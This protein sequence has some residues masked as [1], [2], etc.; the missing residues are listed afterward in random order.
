MRDHSSS[1]DQTS[2]DDLFRG[3]DATAEIHRATDWSATSLGP[4]ATW[5][6]DLRAAVR[7]VLASRIPMLLWWGPDLVQ[8]YN[9]AYSALIGEKHPAAVGQP[10]AACWAEIWADIGPLA[11][12]A[13]AGEATYSHDLPLM[14]RRH[15]YD[16]ETFWTFSYSP[17]RGASGAV[18]GVFVATSD[19]TDAVVR[20]RRLAVLGEIGALSSSDARSAEDVLRHA[21]DILASHPGKVSFAV[22]RLA[23]GTD[24]GMAVVAQHGV[25]DDVAASA[26]PGARSLVAEVLRTGIAQR[27]EAPSGGWPV[28]EAVRRGTAPVVLALHLPLVDRGADRTIAVLTVGINPHRAFDESYRSFLDLVA[29]QI[30]TA[31]TDALAYVRERERATLL[32]AVDRAKTRF[33]QNASHELR[34]PLTVLDGSHRAVLAQPDL[35]AAAHQE[36]AVADR[37]TQR[38]RRLVDG[39][40]DVARAE[41]GGLVPDLVA[42]DVGRL[43]REVASMFRSAATRAGLAL[44][45]RVDGDGTVVDIDAEMWSRIV[46]NL[47]SNA[48]RF[49]R[50]GHVGVELAVA[51]GEVCL[52]V[53]DTGVGIP[54]PEQQ[55]VFERFHQVPGADRGGAGIGLALVRDLAHA[56]GGGVEL[57]SAPGAGSRFRVVVPARRSPDGP[58]ADVD[59]ALD[60]ARPLAEEAATWSTAP[61][62]PEPGA[63]P[64]VPSEAAAAGRLLVVEDD[65]DLRAH[66]AAL[67]QGDGWQVDAVADVPSALARPTPPTLVLSDVMLPGADGIDLVVALRAHPDLADVPVIL[68]TARAGPEAAAEGLA[69]GATDYLTKPFDPT[70]LLARVRAHAEH[71]VRRRAALEA[72]GSKVANLEQALTT[73]RRIGAA[74]GITMARL[75]VT[76]DEA[77]TVL[78]R[79]SQEANRKLREL[80]DEVVLTG[81]VPG[82]AD[83]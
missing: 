44:D 10:A 33:L 9:D 26:R 59:A 5:S 61:A 79:A 68:L 11:A 32:A 53:V 7:T 57:T 1:G 78:R 52:D 41:D 13:A 25:A 14:L 64:A 65:P 24:G 19:T 82:G 81:Q 3:H 72:V 71:H 6:E 60:R 4:V 62:R 47:V 39:L 23:H 42:T 50:R 74:V 63:E 56:L 51:G 48:C 31:M 2:A 69:A 30:S 12:T 8:V 27:E 35:P 76:E 16:E 21:V 17:V 66:L 37:A 18:E 75:R 40:L 80:A 45:V 29:R 34:T 54:V 83:T 58:E 70:E 15:G 46:S 38:L 55:R 43:T 49:T 28:V 73:S 36:L 77:F 20:G 22:A 67:L